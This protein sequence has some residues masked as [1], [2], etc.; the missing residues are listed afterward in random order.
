MLSAYE[1]ETIINYNMSDQNATVYTHDKKL[2]KRLEKLSSKFP[3]EFI[4]MSQSNVGDVTYTF[5]KKYVSIREPYSEAR[6]QAARERAISGN[7][8]PPKRGQN[9]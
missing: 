7:M 4:L 1:R 9:P 8:K 2:I 5:P 6:R 3:D